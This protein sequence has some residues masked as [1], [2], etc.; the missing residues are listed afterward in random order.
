MKFMQK[1]VIFTLILGL[2]SLVGCKPSAEKRPVGEVLAANVMLNNLDS[3]KDNGN[4]TLG[5]VQ[6]IVKYN[7]NA[8]T[9]VDCKTA[10]G[11][12]YEG[13][14]FTIDEA[15]QKPGE[16]MVMIM[17]NSLQGVPLSGQTAP[18][19][20]GRLNFNVTGEG[21]QSI[22]LELVTACDT[23]ADSSIEAGIKDAMKLEIISD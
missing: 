20:L 18:L 8:L 14:A 13:S 3:L 7:T 10:L 15:E 23:A 17:D 21:D 5:G 1:I 11:D 19:E 22:E 2:I 4:G 12:S 16:V 6:F 9:F